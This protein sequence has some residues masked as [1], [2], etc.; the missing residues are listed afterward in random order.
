MVVSLK[1]KS[2][3][4]MDIQRIAHHLLQIVLLKLELEIQNGEQKRERPTTF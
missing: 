2:C 3:L 1:E 4:G